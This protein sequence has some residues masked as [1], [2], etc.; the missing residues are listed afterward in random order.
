MWNAGNNRREGILPK[1]PNSH[2]SEGRVTRGPDLLRK[3]PGVQGL[4]ELVPPSGWVRQ[5][6]PPSQLKA[7]D[8]NGFDGIISHASSVEAV[9]GPPF[10]NSLTPTLS[11]R[12]G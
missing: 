7:R 10:E 3:P 12:D 6:A 5:H 9:A 8:Q 1:Q 2:D 4:T 11:A